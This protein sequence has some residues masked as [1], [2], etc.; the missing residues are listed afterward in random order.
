MEINVCCAAMPSQQPLILFARTLRPLG[1]QALAPPRT[2]YATAAHGAG[3][4]HT[5]SGAAGASP[6]SQ[7]TSRP[8]SQHQAMEG[9]EG[10]EETPLPLVLTRFQLS[11]EYGFLLP[12]PLV[13]DGCATASACYRRQRTGK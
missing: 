10:T 13:G 12:D 3:S 7:S 2:R 6:P 11:E 4:A 1:S 5:G 8:Y 9:G